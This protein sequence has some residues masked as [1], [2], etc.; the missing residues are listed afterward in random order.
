MDNNQIMMYKLFDE[1]VP[2]CGPADTIAGEIVRAF[3]RLNYRNYNDGDHLGVGYGKETCN[4]AG[5]YLASKCGGK[6]ADA[7][8]D[9]WG[10]TSEKAYD[11]LLD[12]L[13]DTV[14]EFLEA[15]PD[16]RDTPNSEDMFDYRDK[17]EDVDD[18]LDDE[19]E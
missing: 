9:A 1:L 6:V 11:T 17:S 19:E 18:S 5:R 14:L 12:I 4:P 3:V 10:V 16:L 2:L 15:N 8:W 13:E 7:V